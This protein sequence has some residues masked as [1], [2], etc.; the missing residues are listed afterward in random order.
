[1]SVVGGQIPVVEQQNIERTFLISDYYL[2]IKIMRLVI[3]QNIVLLVLKLRSHASLK[4]IMT[5]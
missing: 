3:G 5:N 2:F 1:M 4:P